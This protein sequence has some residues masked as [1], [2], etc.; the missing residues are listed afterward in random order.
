MTPE[1]EAKHIF[2]Q[3][4]LSQNECSIWKHNYLL[5]RCVSKTHNYPLYNSIP[6]LQINKYF[7]I[8]PETTLKWFAIYD[9]TWKHNDN[10]YDIWKRTNTCYSILFRFEMFLP[11]LLLK[12][13]LFAFH[14][15]LKFDILLMTIAKL[16]TPNDKCS[17]EEV[18]KDCCED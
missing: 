11:S 17:V 18:Y 9:R 15:T 14:L 1:G 3:W 5:L 8:P 10:W 6:M 2:P 7:K 12:L 16:L 4:M 13:A